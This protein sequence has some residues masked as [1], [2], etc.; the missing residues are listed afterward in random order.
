MANQ[1]KTN[2]ID[3]LVRPSLSAKD[4]NNNNGPKIGR[5]RE[6]DVFSSGFDM[7]PHEVQIKS[8]H[9]AL[10][11]AMYQL[12][13]TTM[14]YEIELDAQASTSQT[15]AGPKKKDANRLPSVSKLSKFK[16]VQAF[17]AA[18]DNPIAQAKLCEFLGIKVNDIAYLKSIQ[19]KVKKV[20]TSRD[21]LKQMIC[22]IF[23]DIGKGTWGHLRITKFMRTSPDP[24]YRFNVSARTVKKYM[25]ELNLVA[26]Q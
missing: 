15:E 26:K 1:L 5:P 19:N 7:L 21:L 4:W 13:A 25:K 20:D 3:F 12:I 17:T 2:P 16:A 11:S 18:A 8:L 10:N 24:K 14:A 23:H 9:T 22:E 6:I